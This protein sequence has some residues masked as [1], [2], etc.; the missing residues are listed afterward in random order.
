FAGISAAIELADADLPPSELEQVVGDDIYHRRFVLGGEE[1]VPLPESPIAV[2]VTRDGAPLAS[3][4]DAE[5]ATGSLPELIAHVAAYL[6][7]FGCDLAAGDVVISGSTVPLIDV[8]PG[9]RV[10]SEVAGVGAVE[11]ALT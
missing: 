4:D 11:V 3:T 7:E 9:Q 6:A 5:A 2:A 1:P 10:R 8:A